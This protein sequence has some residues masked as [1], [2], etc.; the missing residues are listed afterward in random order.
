[1]L[2]RETLQAMTRVV[3]TWLVDL[4]AE[5]CAERL[6]ASPLGRLAVVVDGRPEIFPVNHVYDRATSSVVFPTNAGTKLHGALDWPWVGYEVDGVEQ[7][8]DGGWSVALVGAARE[9]TDRAEIDRLERERH[10]LWAAGP[11]ARWIRIVP[12]KMTGRRISAVV[13]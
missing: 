1:V 2:D 8:G 5:E 6:A 9:I 7:D 3:M 12:S 13:H 11:S 4:S 10:V